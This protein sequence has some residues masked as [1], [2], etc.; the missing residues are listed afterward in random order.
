MFQ[1]IIKNRIQYSHLIKPYFVFIFI[2]SEFEMNFENRILFVL[3]NNLSLN[4]FYKLRSA[5]QNDTTDI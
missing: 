2:K 5:S 1:L 3:K 4:L